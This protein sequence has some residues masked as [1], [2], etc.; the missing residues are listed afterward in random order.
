MSGSIRQL[1]KHTLIY[2]A[3][4]AIG[5]IASFIMLPIYTRYLSPT[6]YGTLEL[7][8]MTIDVISMIAGMGIAS[9]VFK[10][11]NDHEGW[12]WKRQVVST[13]AISLLGLSLAAGLTGLLFAG[14]LSRL[15]L[16]PTGE[17]LYF[18]IFFLIYV[19]HSTTIVPLL[20]LRALQKS[21]LFVAANVLQL[22]V[23]LSLNILFVVGL[24]KGLVGVL[25]G[26]LIATTITAVCLIVYMFRSVGVGF[27]VPIFRRML[28]FGA[29]L[30]VWT[31]GS[32]VLT[33]SDRYFLNHFADTAT[34][35]IYSLGYKF[36][37]ILAAFAVTPFSQV[38]DPQRFEIIKRPDGRDV[39]RR[40]FFYHNLALFMIGMMIIL[41]VR[42]FL[43]I[44]AAPSFL[45]AHRVVPIIVVATILHAWTG[46]CNIGIY[47][48]NRTDLKALASI[49]GVVAATA[50][51][52]A[53]IPRFGMFGAAWATFGAYCVRF[54]TVYYFAQRQYR[55]DYGWSRNWSLMGMVGVAI[56]LRSILEDAPVTISL[57]FS[58]LFAAVS[59][60]T[61]YLWVLSGS[62]RAMV[63]TLLARPFAMVSRNLVDV[64]RG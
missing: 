53:L 41:F 28:R 50:L 60:T 20:L 3:G 32:F 5:K 56:V 13:A 55:I 1:G 57:A 6:D 33:F 8:S 48:R 16:G 12:A 34:V 36:G 14:A 22:V 29:P 25:Y 64:R 37:F 61:I 62:D 2:G 17:P 42:D 54:S 43:A 58:T 39:F 4:I 49:V 38:W 35:G 44:V 31:L 47:I 27:S 30:V 45:S 24:G 18:R 51:N 26:N 23:N 7:L 63:R 10:F 46:Y 9:S 59:I 52:I 11:F 15:I 21:V 40:V 19:L